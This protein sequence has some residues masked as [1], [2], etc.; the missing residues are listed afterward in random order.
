MTVG[1]R[2]SLRSLA[3]F[4]TPKAETIRA[5]GCGT[6]ISGM[7]TMAYKMGFRAFDT[8]SNY[9]T[10][11][12]IADAL[13]QYPRD[14]YWLTSKADPINVHTEDG[15]ARLRAAFDSQLE[16]SGSDY[17]DLFLLHRT[18]WSGTNADVWTPSNV[19]FRFLPTTLKLYLH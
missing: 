14:S 6:F 10:M 18:D 3:H 8:A 1:D 19:P 16:Q 17:L 2:A 9:C 15:E 4:S 13:S 12:A 11:P 7:V 5:S